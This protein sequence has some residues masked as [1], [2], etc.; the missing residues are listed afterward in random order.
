MKNTIKKIEETKIINF[1]NYSLLICERMK[2]TIEYNRKN[3]DSKFNCINLLE[4]N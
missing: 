2:N 3:Q 1:H 4:K